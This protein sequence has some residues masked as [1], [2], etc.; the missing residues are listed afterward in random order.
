LAAAAMTIVDVA[1]EEIW[2]LGL[3]KA[4]EAVLPVVR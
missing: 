2:N 1:G 3:K 4:M